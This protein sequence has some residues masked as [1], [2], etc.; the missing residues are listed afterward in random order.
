MRHLQ[1]NGRPGLNRL[2]WDLEYDPAH[3]IKLR[4]APPGE[5]W[6]TTPEQG[7]RPVVSLLN[8]RGAPRVV[9]GTYTVKL[10]ANGK[11]LSA[12]LVVVRDPGSEATD[13]SIALEVSF[14]RQLLKEYNQVVDMINDLEWQRKQLADL[15]SMLIAQEKPVPALAS[16]RA[17]DG[18]ITA[19]EA[20]MYQIEQTSASIEEGITTPMWLYEK[21]AGLLGNV[22]H[23]RGSGSG[24]GLAPTQAEIDVNNEYE[25]QISSYQKEFSELKEKEIPAL[26]A[27]LKTTGLGAAIA[28]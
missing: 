9:P 14:T 27:G 4:T 16:I 19:L 1:A 10:V 23:G 15:Q 8:F 13:Q 3:V 28:P 11:E 18:K 12:P 21:V 20:K 17:V 22:D 5:P 7:W 25:Q 6:A 24:G 26:N 2:W